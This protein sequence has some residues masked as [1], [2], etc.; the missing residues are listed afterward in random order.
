[1][2]CDEICAV[3]PRAPP[4]LSCTRTDPG[5]FNQQKVAVINSTVRLFLGLHSLTL[6]TWLVLQ[7]E[8]QSPALLDLQ[9]AQWSAV[10]VAHG[11]NIPRGE[12]KRSFLSCLSPAASVCF[13]YFI[14]F[15]MQAVEIKLTLR[16]IWVS[17]DFPHLFGFWSEGDLYVLPRNWMF[18][19]SPIL[20]LE[21]HWWHLGIDAFEPQELMPPSCS[22][23]RSV[24]RLH[25]LTNLVTKQ[26]C[27]NWC[28]P[29]CVDTPKS[30]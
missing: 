2:V 17:L 10:H 28:E 5:V 4:S 8:L 6:A 23:H 25:V 21:S 19:T 30:V 24:P 16:S 11:V 18:V 12:I 26:I 15:L 20:S 29:L 9:W 3:L 13:F 14:F 1:M 27:L 22:Q 7:P